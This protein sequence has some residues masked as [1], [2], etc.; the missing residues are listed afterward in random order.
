LPGAAERCS[1]GSIRWSAYEELPNRHTQLP[2]SARTRAVRPIP[3]RGGGPV[4]PGDC[5][6]DWR[7]AGLRPA[8]GRGLSVAAR[9]AA[10]LRR[11]GRDP[12]TRSPRR[13][14]SVAATRRAPP[15]VPWR[16][17]TVQVSWAAS[18]PVRAASGPGRAGRGRGWARRDAGAGGRNAAFV[19]AGV[20]AGT[21]C[22]EGLGRVAEGGAWQSQAAAPAPR[23]EV[24]V[25][26][27]PLQRST[28]IGSLARGVASDRGCSADAARTC[29][30]RRASRPATAETTADATA[31]TPNGTTPLTSRIAAPGRRRRPTR[32]FRV[33][34]W[35]G[36]A[37]PTCL[38]GSADPELTCAAS[39]SRPGPTGTA[40]PA[41]PTGGRA[42]VEGPWCEPRPSEDGMGP[43][44]CAGRGN[45]EAAH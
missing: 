9:V 45:V 6:P 20:F 31:E 43:T 1:G 12:P 33:R 41:S 18:R 16:V 5:F 39:P 30:R 22:L 36:S 29:A 23:A 42:G 28:P 26:F 44:C 8:G 2:S 21:G 32:S 14:H 35:Q 4:E 25:W 3:A 19:D 40:L 34:S 24:G 15:R 13:A 11:P 37:C 7:A 17:S 10:G 27:V 38:A